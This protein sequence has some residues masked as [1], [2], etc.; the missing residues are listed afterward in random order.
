MIGAMIL[1]YFY[2]FHSLILQ[3]IIDFP[4]YNLKVPAFSHAQDKNPANQKGTQ[5]LLADRARALIVSKTNERRRERSSRCPDKS[6]K[7]MENHAN[8]P[9]AV[10]IHLQRVLQQERNQPITI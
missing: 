9:S 4:L 6:I 3:F 7:H 10:Q 2:E 5:R 8:S 1:P